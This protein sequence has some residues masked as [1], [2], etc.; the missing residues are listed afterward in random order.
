[1]TINSITSHQEM[2]SL[3]LWHKSDSCN[4]PA[5][6]FSIFWRGYVSSFDRVFQF[7]WSPNPNWRWLYVFFVLC[8]GC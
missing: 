1:M 3:T 5:Y 6:L 8:G 2:N 7:L 4:S